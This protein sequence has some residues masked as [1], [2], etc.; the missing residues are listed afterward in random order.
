MVT[1]ES[2]CKVELASFSETRESL[3]ASSDKT[4]KE[5]RMRK[6]M[7]VLK[8]APRLEFQDRTDGAH[9]NPRQY[10]G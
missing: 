1:K 2:L 8:R 4:Q 6:I 9:S 3:N 10:N 7:V 5:V